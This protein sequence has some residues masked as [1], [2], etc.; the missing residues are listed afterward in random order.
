MK[1]DNP[2]KCFIYST[3]WIWIRLWIVSVKNR[4]PSEDAADSNARMLAF[5]HLVQV[6]PP[7]NAPT[8]PSTLSFVGSRNEMLL[9]YNFPSS[10]L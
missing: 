3:A 10:A 9:A 8:Q 2:A 1:I 7:Q 4:T 5:R 6:S